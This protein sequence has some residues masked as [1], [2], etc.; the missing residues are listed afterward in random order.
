ML[1]FSAGTFDLGVASIVVRSRPHVVSQGCTWERVQSEVLRPGQ[2]HDITIRFTND[3]ADVL[4]DARLDLLLPPEL[5]LERAQNA[6]REGA[7]TLHFGEV[8][9]E[10]THEARVSVRLTRPPKRDRTLILEGTLSGRGISPLQF[11]PLEIATFAQPQFAP[12]RG[13]ARTRR[14][15]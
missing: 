6:R 9:A 13:C 7:A 4:R 10:T 5:V 15:M 3:G 2:S 12:E 14:K 11:D 8:P 1:E